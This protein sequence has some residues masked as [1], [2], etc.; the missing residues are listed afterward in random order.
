MKKLV[1]S[2]SLVLFSLISFAMPNEKVLSNFKHTFP[3]AE[4][5]TWYDNEQY[6][7]VHFTNGE[8]KCRLWYDK[9]GAVTKALRYYSKEM[10]YPL[11]LSSL[12]R[13]HSDKT[14]FGVT[15]LTNEDGV[16]FYIVLED[17]KKWYHVTSDISGNLT[18]TKTFKK[19]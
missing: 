5:I 11:I 16:H 1:I 6:Y 15:E 12:Q 9:E 19:A 18:L 2:M 14:I 4:S 13:K 10:L 3:K 17:A 8:V 7:E